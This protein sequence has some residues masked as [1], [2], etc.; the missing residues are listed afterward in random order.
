M[1][2]L[3]LSLDRGSWKM[4]LSSFGAHHVPDSENRVR[5]RWAPEVRP[6]WYRGATVIVPTSS[7]RH[8][9]P[10]PDADGVATFSAPPAG[11]G[12]RFDVLLGEPD[13]ESLTI[14]YAEDVGHIALDGRVVWVVM[15]ELPIDG[16]YEKGIR[17][18]AEGLD[19]QVTTA[20]SHPRGWAWGV[21]DEDGGPVLVD[22]GPIAPE[23][24][25]AA[26]S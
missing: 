5:A 21:D 23:H 20:T 26:Q 19:G 8:A 3:G 14:A 24:G 12:L 2:E 16:T 9:P 7:I 13:R 18:L 22:L 11:W 25:S 17:S 6:G 10:V 4:S 15:T 1:G